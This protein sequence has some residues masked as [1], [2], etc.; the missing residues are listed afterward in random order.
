[1]WRYI[2]FYSIPPDILLPGMPQR[3]QRVHPGGASRAH[4]R[5]APRAA[6]GRAARQRPGAQRL[7]QE[8]HHEE[9]ALVIGVS[10]Q[11]APSVGLVKQIQWRPLWHSW[12][13]TSIYSA[14]LDLWNITSTQRPLVDLWYNISV[15]RSLVAIVD[16]EA[17]RDGC[18]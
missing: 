7:P 10:L 8:A 9:P 17:V 2:F 14:L 5:L 16:A 15:Q 3:K 11:T 12:E 4:Q 18:V 1:M 6:G 13:T